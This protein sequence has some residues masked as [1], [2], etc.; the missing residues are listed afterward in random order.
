M[1]SKITAQTSAK[2]KQLLHAFKDTTGL[3]PNLLIVG[4]NGEDAVA[5]DIEIWG[6]RIVVNDFA[7]KDYT[8]GFTL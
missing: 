8:V 3:V 2:I 4:P 6:M 5:E 1:D 7:P